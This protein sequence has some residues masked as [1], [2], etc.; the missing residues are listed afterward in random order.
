MISLT[1]SCGF[2]SMALRKTAVTPVRIQ[3]VLNL[4][5]ILQ[6]LYRISYDNIC[7]L[8]RICINTYDHSWAY[9]HQSNKV[10]IPYLCAISIWVWIFLY[11]KFCPC[12]YRLMSA[13]SSCLFAKRPRWFI[14]SL[15]YINW[16]H[17]KQVSRMMCSNIYGCQI[18]KG[19]YLMCLPV[20]GLKFYPMNYTS[21]FQLSSMSM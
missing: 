3:C 12:V 20:R 19:V 8:F 7:Q 9:W 14:S 1:D 2:I 4:W 17:S 5:N 6:Y 10:Q 18:I 13:I 16:T 21:S 11:H 15:E